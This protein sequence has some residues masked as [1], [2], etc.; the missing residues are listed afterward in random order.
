MPCLEDKYRDYQKNGCINWDEY[1]SNPYNNRRKVVYVCNDDFKYGTLRV[2]QPC[3]IKLKEDI[4]FN[5]DNGDD[6]NPYCEPNLS[7]KKSRYIHRGYVLG[8][9]AALTIECRDV[10]VDLNHYEI[11]QSNKH[12]VLQRF[13]AN[14][15]LAD[16][17]FL[18]KQGPGNFGET[19]DSATNCLIMNG[20]LGQSS[21]H[22]IHGNDNKNITIKKLCIYL[23]EVAGVALNGPQDV[24]IE[25]C[26]IDGKFE[27]I[28]I[29]GI[30]SAA[31][32]LRQFAKHMITRCSKDEARDDLEYKLKELEKAI[33]YV[34]DD[35]S[36]H[37]NLG[38]VDSCRDLTK[39]F[40]NKSGLPD[41]TSYGII[42]NGK[43]VAVGAFSNKLPTKYVTKNII[44]KRVNI[45]NITGKLH[46]VIALS[47]GD[48]STGA[49]YSNAGVQTDTA[50]SVFQIKEVLND[51]TELYEGNVVSDMQ[52]AI[53]RWSDEYLEGH[54][55]VLS[56]ARKA[57][58]LGTLN[59]KSAIVAWCLPNI[60]YQGDGFNVTHEMPFSEVMENTGI[61]YLGNGDSMF[62]VNKGFFGIRMDSVEDACINCNIVNVINKG[63]P[64][65]NCPGPYTGA[66]DGGHTGQGQMIGYTGAEAYGI[67]LSACKNIQVYRSIIKCVHSKNGTIWGINI[68]GASHHVEVYCSEIECC[69]SNAPIYNKMPNKVPTAVGIYVDENSDYVEIKDTN[70]S[71]IKTKNIQHGGHEIIFENDNNNTVE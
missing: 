44:I 6:S 51:T 15:E 16:Q 43:G 48:E 5:P 34:V 19:I 10:I 69:S 66:Q 65:S 52:I 30:F 64:G 63:N 23:F 29:L 62:H 18:P 12:Y 33:D 46:E 58:H 57:G 41:G 59:I 28:P 68:N 45:K 49:S 56:D 24:N 47:S 8:F 37:K 55:P 14:I 1:E 7:H 36:S 25:D 54:D 40:I 42:I 21:H 2:T 17:P 35:C 71:K 4:I 38:K 39:V 9:F 31:M 70:L 50:G 61:D 27:D 13:Y 20:K 67:C 60:T 53:A 32:F 26:C 22:G 11:R 3:A